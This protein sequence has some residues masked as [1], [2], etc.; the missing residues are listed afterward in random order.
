VPGNCYFALGAVPRVV[1]APAPQADAVHDAVGLAFVAHIWSETLHLNPKL[2][3][4]R[5]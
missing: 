1:R 3:T 2:A 4:V 5:N